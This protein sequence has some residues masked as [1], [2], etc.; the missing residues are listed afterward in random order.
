LTDFHRQRH[1]RAP[2]TDELKIMN[3]GVA[4]G[5]PK[6]LEKLELLIKDYPPVPY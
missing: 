3:R 2:C 5:D 4:K 1:L 6:S